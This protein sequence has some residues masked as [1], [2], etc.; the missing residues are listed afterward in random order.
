MGAGGPPACPQDSA[1]YPQADIDR[2]TWPLRASGP[3]FVKRRGQWSPWPGAVDS[4]AQGALSGCV[5]GGTGPTPAVGLEGRLGALADSALLVRLPAAQAVP[6]ALLR[7]PQTLS[8]QTSV[9]SSF[10]LLG[11]ISHPLETVCSFLPVKPPPPPAGA[12]WSQAREGRWVKGWSGSIPGPGFS[13][14]SHAEVR[15]G[16][17]A[18]GSQP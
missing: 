14:D 13:P 17:R 6:R 9:P 12:S 7:S 18:P 3:S 16:S 8:L 10:W 15:A 5:C 4:L 1:V 11:S 2:V